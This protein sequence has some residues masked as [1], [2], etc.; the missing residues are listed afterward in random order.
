[1]RI[2][3]WSSD[4]C[5]SDLHLAAGA[6][7]GRNFAAG[8][9]GIG[10]AGAA[11]ARR[12]GALM[13]A[14]DIFI[15]RGARAAG[16]F[17]R[18]VRIHDDARVIAL[19]SHSGAGKTSVLHAIAGLVAPREGRTEVDGRC[20]FDAAA[21]IDVTVRE[22]EVGYVVPEERLLPQHIASAHRSRAEK[23]GGGRD[24]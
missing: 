19:A 13:L 16:G 12:R 2:S 17:R 24:G 10:V 1:M 23:R 9:A 22:S 3:D 6:G 8:A 7:G 15:E 20:L 5:S 11:P 14:L 4:V 21:G 18:H